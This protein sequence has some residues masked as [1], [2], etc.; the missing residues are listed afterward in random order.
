MININ[1]KNDNNNCYLS[2]NNIQYIFNKDNSI[3]IILNNNFEVIDTIIYDN[4]N[5]SLSNKDIN[6][7][8]IGKK[9]NKSYYIL[10]NLIINNYVSCIIINKI[11][12]DIIINNENADLNYI[13]KT[14]NYE[15]KIIINTLNNLFDKILYFY[16]L[17]NNKIFIFDNNEN[18]N[19]NELIISNKY[20]IN[21]D[22][23]NIIKNIIKEN[24]Y[25]IT[26]LSNDKECLFINN[27]VKNKNS[28][29]YINICLLWTKNKMIEILPK[30]YIYYKNP[31]YNLSL[32]YNQNYPNIIIQKYD[33]NKKNMNI[34]YIILDN[35]YIHFNFITQIM[36]YKII[37]GDKIS[38][39]NINLL[40][41]NPNEKDNLITK[42]KFK[43][44]PFINIEKTD[45]FIQ[46]N[47]NYDNLS[48][49]ISNITV[50]DIHAYI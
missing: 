27:N 5:I 22:Y 10:N 8:I 48:I 13:Y 16:L 34:N 46:F 6:C 40:Q 43:M 50:N 14:L 41:I 17:Q 29:N 19:N 24:K 38:N 4:M 7:I 15:Y 30:V 25:Y 39:I 31:L 36:Y 2:I 35:E 11:L 20:Y 9:I 23:D 49:N 45:K 42:L 32:I 1:I 44:Y 28:V 26:Y 37:N 47:Y 18:I 3:K 33:E 12:L 21:K